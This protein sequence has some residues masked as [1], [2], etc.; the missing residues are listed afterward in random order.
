MDPNTSAI[1]RAFHMAKSGR[2]TDV[3]GVKTALSAEGYSTSAIVGRVL[4][5]QLRK[6]IRDA[7]SG[8]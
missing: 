8:V 3:A 7:K 6:L 4:L 1:E 2:F 5:A